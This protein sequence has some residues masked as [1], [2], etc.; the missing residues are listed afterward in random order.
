[1]RSIHD[2]FP[3]PYHFAIIRKSMAGFEFSLSAEAIVPRIKPTRG[4]LDIPRRWIRIPLSL[5]KH[6]IFASVR[7]RAHNVDRF[8]AKAD[9]VGREFSTSPSENLRLS[10]IVTNLSWVASIV[11]SLHTLCGSGAAEIMAQ[12][13]SELKK[14]TGQSVCFGTVQYRF[15]ADEGGIFEP[16]YLED[17]KRIPVGEPFFIKNADHTVTRVLNFRR[18]T[19]ESQIYYFDED[20]PRLGVCWNSKVVTASHSPR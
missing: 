10:T 8:I 6:Q 2:R 19:E 3:S 5:G 11:R 12:I 15:M 17:F 13:N 7:C 20:W 16:Q 9:G 4:P 1:M 14:V 18:P